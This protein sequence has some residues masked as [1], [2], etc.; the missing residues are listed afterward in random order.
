[1]FFI[2]EENVRP[3]NRGGRDRFNWN[4]IRL[5]NNKD[6]ESYLGVTQSIGFLDKGGKWRKRDWWQSHKSDNNIDMEE[7]RS[8]RE[9]VKMEE[10]RLI[11]ERIYGKEKTNIIAK[12][13][14]PSA[15][16][17]TDYEWKELMKKE[18]NFENPEHKPIDY[19]DND[20]HKAGLGIKAQISFRTNPYDQKACHNLSRLNGVNYE[21]TKQTKAKDLSAYLDD[22]DLKEVKVEI[23]KDGGDRNKEEKNESKRESRKDKSHKDEKDK[24]KHK[25]R[26]RSR[27]RSHKKHKKDK[28]DRKDKHK[29]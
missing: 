22:A 15:A 20:E 3:G 17:L 6:R 24:K 28:K 14:E 13:E 8:E 7:I 29:Y 2:K 5:M 23:K 10:E 19:Y 25:K 4:D 1:M 21:N 11:N 18:S 27:S 12:K 16:T 9:R 26:S